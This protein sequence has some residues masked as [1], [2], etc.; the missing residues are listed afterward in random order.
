MAYSSP[1]TRR[2]FRLNEKQRGWFRHLPGLSAAQLSLLGFALL[3]VIGSLLLYLPMSRREFTAGGILIAIFESTSAVCVTGLSLVDISSYYTLTGQLCLLLL[4]QV[5]G[6][7][8]M[9][10]YS[11]MMLAVGRRLSLRER[12]AL[13]QV[14][15]LS[16][17]G[18]VVG[19][20]F[21][22]LRLT[23]A[24][25]ALG[26]MLL[27]LVWV[28]EYGWQKGLYLALFHA[29][30]AFNNAGFST[31]SDSLIRFDTQPI[32]LGTIAGLII[33]GSMGYPVLAE[34]L[35]RLQQRRLKWRELSLHSRVSLLMTGALLLFGTLSYLLIE[36][37]RP[38]TLGPMHPLQKLLAAFFMSVTPRTA[39]FNALD[40]S[41][42]SQ[43][44]LFIT[45]S[46][47][48]VGANPGGTGGGIKTTT[49][50]VA[51]KHV[52]SILRGQHETELF[53]R[54]LSDTTQDKAWATLL[55][56]VLWING[57]TILL[58]LTEGDKPLLPVL[59]EVISAF[60]TVGMTVGYTGQL[61]PAGQLLII[62][63]MYVG[64]VG[65]MTLGMAIWSRR[66]SKLITYPEESLLVS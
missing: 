59:F 46:L 55:I 8:Y 10:M 11:L 26:F 15:D 14:L 4:I 25:E 28:P 21:Q 3:I 2:E 54:R 65:V 44:S 35:T 19:F 18:G 1:G 13:Q 61:S 63:T 43:A 22:I 58:T 17:P 36:A 29:V 62:A 60:A 6:L 30:S 56:S 57:T 41:L 27:A 40:L 50:L 32:V 42:L 52:L 16:G 7:G 12:L 39:G 48:L 51:V 31:F 49:L 5:G 38:G 47:M 37:N 23:L 53:K 24:I 20:L 64:R 45:L 33:L 66:E 34:L 9:T